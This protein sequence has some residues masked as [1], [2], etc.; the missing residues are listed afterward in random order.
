MVDQAGN[1]FG[2]TTLG[3]ANGDGAVYEVSP[4]GSGW[5]ESIIHSFAVSDGRDPWAGLI[6]DSAGNL[7]G[8]TLY[9]GLNNSGVVFELS[10][11]NGSYTYSVLYN[12]SGGDGSASPL[13][14]DTAGNLY[15]VQYAGAN[16][17]G[18]IFKLTPGNG[19]WIFTDLHDFNGS[20]GSQPIGNLALDAS[21]NLYG[22]T[23]NGGAYGYGV[24]WEVTP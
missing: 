4:S 6:S 9:G 16:D 20:D 24:I 3:G 10:P 22:T 2:T 14:M 8:V 1:I 17:H 11:L 21:D 19:G 18:M 12:I 5:S 23:E 13:S 7:Y 15:G